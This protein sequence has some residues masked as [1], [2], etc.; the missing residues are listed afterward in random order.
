MHQASGLNKKITEL[1]GEASLVFLNMPPFPLEH[2]VGK[3]N[4]H[5]CV[6]C[7]YRRSQVIA[8]FFTC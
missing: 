1:S 7:L 6:P 3:Y 2:N 4:V 5:Y 8:P